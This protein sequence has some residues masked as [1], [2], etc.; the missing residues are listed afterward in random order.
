MKPR[1]VFRFAAGVTV[2]VAVYSGPA[3]AQESGGAAADSAAQNAATDS[4]TL[5]YERE[6][7]TYPRLSRRDPYGPLIGDQGLGPRIEDLT[8][9]GIIHS[10][11][12]SVA[13]LVDGGGKNYRVREGDIVGSARVTGIEPLRVYFAVRQF[14]VV[15]QQILEL[16]RK[17]PGGNQS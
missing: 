3:K 1:N 2:L 11:A 16:V 17:E 7:F 5:V 10:P 9:K 14:G 12:G 4:T 6:V 15:Q 8:L 13:L